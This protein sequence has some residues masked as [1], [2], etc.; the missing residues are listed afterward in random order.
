MN[1]HHL[2]DACI[3]GILREIP[4]SQKQEMRVRVA[5]ETEAERAIDELTIRVMRQCG[6]VDCP[7]RP[8]PVP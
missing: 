2:I 3:T 1:A 5:I 4:L 7:M 8:R 6:H